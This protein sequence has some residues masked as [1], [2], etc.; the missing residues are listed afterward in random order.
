MI[1]FD[2]NIS[3]ISAHELSSSDRG[4]KIRS[5]RNRRDVTTEAP[6]CKQGD[7]Y[8]ED[9]NTCT[10]NEVGL[11]VC[12]RRACYDGPQFPDTAPLTEAPRHRRDVTTESPKCKQGDSYQ[13]DCNTCTCNEVGLFV[14]TRRACYDGPQFPD[15][16][17]LTEA[18]RHRRDV[19]TEAPKCKQ[20]DSYQEDCNTCT[21]NEVGL[22]VCTRRA[23]YDGPQFPDTAPL[24]EAPRHRR[25]VTTEAPK[26]KQGDSYQED[27]NTCT[28]NEL[29]LFVCTRRA[30]YDGP[31]FPD[32]APLTEAPRHRRD[33]N[34]TTGKYDP[35]RVTLSILRFMPER[36]QPGFVTKKVSS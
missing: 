18:P 27:C 1:T 21:C 35:P 31:Q 36:C 17:P 25:D 22:F 30:C 28:C 19:T 8:Q 2:Q 23:C 16:A 9:C 4:L 20:G 14:C 13:E 11:F 24:T 12:T 15:T 33:A 26:C 7:S 3:A 5:P 29:G 34:E 32:T 6:K 10:C